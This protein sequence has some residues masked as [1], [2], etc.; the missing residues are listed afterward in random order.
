ME[1]LGDRH[2]RVNIPPSAFLE[3]EKETVFWRL[4]V[5]FQHDESPFLSAFADYPSH[6]VGIFLMMEEAITFAV[7]ILEMTEA[8]SHE[9]DGS[10]KI[11]AETRKKTG[12]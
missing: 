8:V 2:F 11:S 4:S 12:W 1:I 7:S 10:L 3:L 5:G 9:P 6:S